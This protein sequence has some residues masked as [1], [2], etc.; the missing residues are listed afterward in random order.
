M[1]VIEGHRR[2]EGMVYRP[3]NRHPD[4]SIGLRLSLPIGRRTG[5]IFIVLY[6]S[7]HELLLGGYAIE[8]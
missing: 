4:A 7:R 6:G 5:I 8:Q 1:R 2:N 3:L